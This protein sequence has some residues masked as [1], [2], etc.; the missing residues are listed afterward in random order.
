MIAFDSVG[1]HDLATR[2][3][4]GPRHMT[5]KL[6]FVG[7]LAL[8][9]GFS[10]PSDDHGRTMTSYADLVALFHDWRAF[11]QPRMVAGV[12][13]YSASAMAAQHAALAGYQRRLAAIDTTGWPVAQQVDYHIVRAEMNGL[14]FSH[15]VLRPWARNPAF[16]VSFYPSRSDQPA[17]EGTVPAGAIELWMWQFPLSPERESEL[18]AKLRTIPGFLHEARTNLDGNARDLWMYGIQSVAQQSADLAALSAR[19]AKTNP[20]VDSAARQAREATDQFRVWLEQQAPSRTG[21]SGIG[22]DNYNWYLKNVQLVP[23]TWAEEEVLMQ[24]ELAR[25]RA[26][27]KLEEDR[28]RKLP[29][30]APIATEAAYTARFNSAVTEYMA[31]LR[32][33]EVLTVRDYMD[34]ALRA[35]VGS[36]S[37]PDPPREFFDEVNYRD[38]IVMLT[39][40][41]HWIDLARMDAEPHPDPIRRG[42]LLYNVFVTRTEGFATA[43]EEMMM[44]EGFLDGHPR[45]NE[46]IYVLIAERAAR[47][48]SDL[49]LQSNDFTME[50]AKQ[51]AVDWTPRGWLRANSATV[52]GE[53]HLYL[54]QPAYGTS[55]II[56]KLQFDQLLNERSAQLG[57]GYSTKRFMDEFNGAGLIPMSLI[58]WELT[59]NA[60]EIIAMTRDASPAASATISPAA[61]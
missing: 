17:R 10:S 61:R 49:H 18:V 53:Q 12:P 7:M 41:Y 38:P 15:R 40:D 33:H 3:S 30:I 8:V 5:A 35:R 1:N 52:S 27:L 50:Q 24:R 55:Y 28:N 45:S 6:A 57:D 58:R 47:A 9:M 20:A 39:H 36:F 32:D 51:F 25:S 22:I 19:V 46:L 54:Q 44:H 13:D 21:P 34:P 56:G 31:F 4:S 26:A 43:M 48:L 2:E 23:F 14:D 59:G 16:Y 11:E 37:P 60:D 42:P 29:P